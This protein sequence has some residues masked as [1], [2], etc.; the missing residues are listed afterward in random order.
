MIDSTVAR[1]IDKSYWY[2]I[3]THDRKEAQ[4]RLGSDT[5][6]MCEQTSCE[7]IGAKVKTRTAYVRSLPAK[8]RVHEN[9]DI[10]WKCHWVSV[11]IC[12]RSR[13]DHVMLKHV[14]KV[15]D[16]NVNTQEEIK[17]SF[18]PALRQG[19]FRCIAMFLLAGRC[20]AIVH[21]DSSALSPPS[22]NEHERDET[23]HLQ[24]TRDAEKDEE[25]D[26][27][28]LVRKIPHFNKLT[29][30]REQTIRVA[31]AKVKELL[32]KKRHASVTVLLDLVKMLAVV[33]VLSLASGYIVYR[34][35]NK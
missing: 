31:V 25:R 21:A 34:V 11:R 22:A 18:G 1:F 12:Y 3:G 7:K 20:H 27:A 4:P 2:R 26:V 19:C 15:G 17:G 9:L 33:A 29:G 6:K 32:K 10:A 28:H 16:A 35:S 23:R 8:K 13:V 30:P 14:R 5:L 24:G